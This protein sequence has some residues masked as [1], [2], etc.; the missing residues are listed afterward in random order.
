[1]AV[2]EYD[3]PITLEQVE[4][5]SGT[6]Q[7]LKAA[8]EGRAR[9]ERLVHDGRSQGDRHPLHLHRVR[10]ARLRRDRGAGDAPAACPPRSA[11]A[12]ARAYNELFS[13]HGITMIFLFASPVLSGFSVSLFPLILGTRDMAFPRLNAFSYWLFLVSGVFIYAGFVMGV[14]PND[15]WFNYPPYALKQ[16]NPGPN[17]DFYALG[18]ILFGISSTAGAAI[19]S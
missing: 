5:Q 12:D 18:M 9:L 17:M 1:M 2:T 11:S 7:K 6:A 15:G 3:R 4:P 16:Y 10:P 19:S 8:V 14:G 13:M